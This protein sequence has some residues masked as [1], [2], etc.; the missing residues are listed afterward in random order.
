MGSNPIWGSDF[1]ESTFLL[2][3]NVV[4]ENSGVFEKWQN[5]PKLAKIVLKSVRDHG[6]DMQNVYFFRYPSVSQKRRLLI[7]S[8]LKLGSDPYCKTFIFWLLNFIPKNR[9]FSLIDPLPKICCSN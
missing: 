4:V 7:S 1:S 6:H 5:W 8:L 9:A 2:E 3:K